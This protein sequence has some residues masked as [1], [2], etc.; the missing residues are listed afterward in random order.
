MSRLLRIA[1]LADAAATTA[2]A[3]LLIVFSAPFESLLG[4]PP[5]FSRTIGYGLLPYAAIVAYLG[6]RPQVSR[7][8]V[9]AVIICNVIWVVD[10]ALLLMGNW[11][12]PTPLGVS[13][14]I[15]QAV[16]V[17]AFAD[18]QFLG[19]APDGGA[20]RVARGRARLRSTA[21]CT[22]LHEA[23]GTHTARGSRH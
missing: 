20:R 6:T 12:D 17:A 22:A 1:L 5:A 11:I 14:V 15:A 8:A 21:L 16:A 23:R 13:F 9:W 18:V 2:T 7:G 3:L 10:S 4:L 19:T